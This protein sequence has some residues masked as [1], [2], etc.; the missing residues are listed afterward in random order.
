MTLPC[1]IYYFADDDNLSLVG[2]KNSKKMSKGNILYLL[3]TFINA[4]FMPKINVVTIK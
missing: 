3:F 2:Y 1:L 4:I